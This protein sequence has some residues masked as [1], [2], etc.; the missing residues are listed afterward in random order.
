[1]KHLG[2][3]KSRSK[4]AVFCSFALLIVAFGAI[5][6]TIKQAHAGM[7]IPPRKPAVPE[8]FVQ[9]SQPAEFLGFRFMGNLL[10]L[11]SQNESGLP[12]PA[13]KPE[14]LAQAQ[15]PA[16]DPDFDPASLPTGPMAAEQIA[17]YKIVFDLQDAGKI[18]EAASVYAK[19][20]DQR[21]RGHV[22]YQRYMHPT[23]YKSNFAE[24]QNWL[25]HYADLPGS[26]DIYALAERKKSGEGS[27]KKP[28]LAKRISE[29][30]QEPTMRP[31]KIYVSGYRRNAQEK[32]AVENLNKRIDDFIQNRR[33]AQAL[34]EIQAS[35]IIDPVEKDILRSDISAAYLHIQE[36]EKAYK[37]AYQALKSSGTHVP[38]AAWVAGLVAWK[39]MNYKHA[40]RYFEIS[41]VS[42]Y[43]S[44]WMSAAGS[45]WAAR[46]HMRMGNVKDVSLWL[47]MAA[48]YPRTFYGLL[49]T[50]SLGRDFDFNWNTPEFTPAHEQI[51][52]ETPG[53]TRAL[54]LVAAGQEHLA[55]SELV[56]M[57]PQT[58]EMR[59][60]MIAYAAHANLPALS[61]RLA[62]AYDEQG[63][64][65]DA[66]LYPETP[67]VP[68]GGFQVDPALVH[69]IMRQES[70]FDP[71]A[72][73]PSGAR[74]LMQLMPSTASYI[75]G[76][77]KWQSS[78]G[79]HKLM[80]PAA[81][82]ELGQKYLLDLLGQSYIKGDLLHMLVAYN[83]GPGNLRKWQ[84][85]W[86]DVDDSLLFIELIPARETRAYVE[87]VLANYWIYR[88]RDGLETASLDALA[89]GREA[90]YAGLETGIN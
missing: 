62:N 4:R 83:A 40:A 70:R 25:E 38:K 17:L 32:R 52:R 71:R 10:N 41:A 37:I 43:G 66:A 55:E 74:G 20:K 31:G 11:P 9:A 65:F 79:K 85:M 21:L 33:L 87:R 82:L 61:I 30:Y 2:C 80:Q 84:K 45:F 28:E 46:A 76:S 44:G 59:E 23:A 39:N 68:K 67:W 16:L 47:D 58:P 42:P 35:E 81:N 77:K 26:K 7:A 56:H 86:P 78:E 22:L 53:G 60:A 29:I 34:K 6:I 48:H 54:M 27:L 90:R 36:L 5:T 89:E 19:I 51:L 3:Q 14:T 69:A 88:L 64:T 57:P 63:L 1:M 15:K 75:G 18:D 72:E 49:A 8:A 13:R 73:S 24:L 50:R 12:L